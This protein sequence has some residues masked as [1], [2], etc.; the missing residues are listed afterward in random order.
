MF[1]FAMIALMPSSFTAVE[2][3]IFC[4]L[5]TRKTGGAIKRSNS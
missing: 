5:S 2:N 3:P 1:F 4:W